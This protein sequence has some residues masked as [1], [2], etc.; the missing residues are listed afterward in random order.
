MVHNEMVNIWSHFLG[1]VLVVIVCV[2]LM[3]SFGNIDIDQFKKQLVDNVSY[4]LQP[5][6]NELKELD[7]ILNDKVSKGVATIKQDYNMLEGKVID[8]FNQLINQFAHIKDEITPTNIDVDA[9]VQKF[10]QFSFQQYYDDID[11]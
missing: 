11:L 6:Y 4:Q 8:N 5:I 2:F 10:K 9:I 7:D 1:A 3:T